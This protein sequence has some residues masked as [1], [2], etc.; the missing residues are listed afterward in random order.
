VELA[1]PTAII[2][3]FG[4]GGKDRVGSFHTAKG[5]VDDAQHTSGD[6]IVERSAACRSEVSAIVVDGVGGGSG[7][8]S[9]AGSRCGFNDF[10][11]R[12]PR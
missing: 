3:S 5:A 7:S 8:E 11:R 12:G 9:G 6:Q 1:A 4:G 10:W 2:V